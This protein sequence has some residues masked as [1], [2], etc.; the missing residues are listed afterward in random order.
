MKKGRKFSYFYI[1]L[2]R[3]Q[4]VIK[5]YLC[6]YESEMVWWKKK[7]NYDEHAINNISTFISA[8]LFELIKLYSAWIKDF[9]LLDLIT[10]TWYS[11]SITSYKKR[12]NHQFSDQSR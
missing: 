12:K 5:L 9:F 11:E 3:T 6:L 2:Q 1:F 10:N 8:L 7:L 4:N